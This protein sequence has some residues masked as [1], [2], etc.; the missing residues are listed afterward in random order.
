MTALNPL[1]ILSR[2]YGAVYGKNGKVFSSVEDIRAGDEF[3][4]KMRDGNITATA[5]DVIR[6]NNGRKKK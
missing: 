6:K 3:S 5:V 1:S 2:G 4:L